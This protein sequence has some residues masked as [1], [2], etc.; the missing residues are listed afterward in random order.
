M[1][2]S[3]CLLFLEAYDYVITFCNEI[4][5]TFAPFILWCE[6]GKC[7]RVSRSSFEIYRLKLSV[8]NFYYHILLLC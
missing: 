5:T 8:H 3:Y 7:R 4:F 6:S 2:V 1:N